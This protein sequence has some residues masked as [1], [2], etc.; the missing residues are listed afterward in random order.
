MS[1]VDGLKLTQVLDEIDYFIKE[2]YCHRFAKIRGVDGVLLV[3]P[4]GAVKADDDIIYNIIVLSENMCSSER[5]ITFLEAMIDEYIRAKI[6]YEGVTLTW[7]INVIYTSVSNL[8]SVIHTGDEKVMACVSAKVYYTSTTKE[9]V[10]GSTN[11]A[12]GY[13]DIYTAMFEK[14]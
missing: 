10:L 12:V 2:C 13:D 11:V 5:Q 6:T 1:T 4:N 3:R 9:I 7:N 14:F 8:K